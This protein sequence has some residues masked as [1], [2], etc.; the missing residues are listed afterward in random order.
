MSTLKLKIPEKFL[1][2]YLLMGGNPNYK[3]MQCLTFNR[4]TGLL[5]DSVKIC[6]NCSEIIPLNASICP[7]CKEPI[8]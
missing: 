8:L 3:D 5:D 7:N 1:D 2:M 6:S 4:K